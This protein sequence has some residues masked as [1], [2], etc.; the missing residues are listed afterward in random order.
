LLAALF[1]F[2]SAL[3]GSENMAPIAL[4]GLIVMVLYL[5]LCLNL[6]PR[7]SDLRT[8]KLAGWGLTR[9]GSGVHLRFEAWDLEQRVRQLTRETRRRDLGAMEEFLREGEAGETFTS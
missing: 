4:T 2:G 3:E 8:L 5:N 6:V 9:D 1:P 7:L